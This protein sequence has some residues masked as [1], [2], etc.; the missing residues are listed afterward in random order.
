MKKKFLSLMMAA[1]VVAS[2]SVSAFA[3]TNTNEKVYDITS[4]TKEHKVEIT[5][6][7]TDN[8]NNKVPGTISVTV[9]TAVSFTINK[10]GKI[11]GGDI[12]IKN[13]SEDKV[14]VVVKKF[15][16]TDATGGIVLVK[17]DELA[18]NVE[19]DDDSKVHASINIVS[20]SNSVALVSSTSDSQTG[21]IDS[22]GHGVQEDVGATLGE[23][24]NDN[25]LKL[26]LKGKTK[27]DISQKTYRAPAKALNNNFNLVFK[28]QK[29]TT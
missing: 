4:G 3:D 15:T 21:L 6:N 7:V 23:A 13:T 28:I 11:T 8:Q 22:E 1:A 5:G 10:D 12:V 29:S 17:D 16:D 2:T 14:K 20:G 24:W 9:P 19:N 26:S 27:A 18:T 25:P